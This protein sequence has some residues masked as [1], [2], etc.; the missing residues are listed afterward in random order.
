MTQDIYI[1][2]VETPEITVSLRKD[3]IV[4]VVIKPNTHI[5]IEVQDRMFEAY[6]KITEIKRPFL[7][8]GGEFV[9][10]TKEA[11]ERSAAKD[12]EIPRTATALYVKNLGQ[13][14]I[15]D[16]YHKINKPKTPV[17]VF[18]SFDAGIKWLTENYLD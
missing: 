15:A 7:I 6:C 16:F 8:E 2:K 1:T 4:H 9:S 5:T 18:K 11:R 10:V 13:K 17:K 14:I 3:G 12:G